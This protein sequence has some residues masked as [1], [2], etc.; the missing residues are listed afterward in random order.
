LTTI[1][2][3][4]FSSTRLTIWREKEIQVIGRKSLWR[5]ISMRVKNVL[6]K[7]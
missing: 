4:F 2:I 7:I 1:S 5:D 6:I 3:F